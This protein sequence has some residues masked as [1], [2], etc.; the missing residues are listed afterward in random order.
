MQVGT[1]VVE[2][3]LSIYKHPSDENDEVDEEVE[4]AEE[5]DVEL[6]DAGVVQDDDED[7]E[8]RGIPFP[9]LRFRR[10]SSPTRE[11]S[12]PQGLRSTLTS[13]LDCF[14]SPAS[15]QS[16][17]TRED[18]LSVLSSSSPRDSSSAQQQQE[19]LNGLYTQNRDF[20]SVFL[21][22]D[23]QYATSQSQL[24]NS[25]HS[26]AHLQPLV[27]ADTGNASP[28]LSPQRAQTPMRID[29]SAAMTPVVSAVSSPDAQ[30]SNDSSCTSVEQ[31]DTPQPFQSEKKRRK[32]GSVAPF[33][34]ANTIGFP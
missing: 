17:E 33:Q 30:F 24:S 11:P 6:A 8:P 5:D 3:K 4:D 15:E 9:P 21:N 28:H 12:A 31:T 32:V 13:L 19:Q 34:L 10:S 25:P 26:H 16:V 7:F 27:D 18:E 22:A 2:H 23:D 20:E 29:S 1:D 14:Q